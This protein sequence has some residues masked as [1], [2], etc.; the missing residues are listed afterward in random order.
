M[1]SPFSEI[2]PAFQ[3]LFTMRV[4]GD[5]AL[6]LSCFEDKFEINRCKK[7]DSVS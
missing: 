7:T 3:K 4:E 2:E 6:H 1:A 5:V